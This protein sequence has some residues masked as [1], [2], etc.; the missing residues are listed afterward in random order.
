MRT[1]LA[2]MLALAAMTVPALAQSNPSAVST[3]ASRASIEAVGAGLAVVGK[4]I[5]L[6]PM[7]VAAIGKG[8]EAGARPAALP[9]GTR[10]VTAGPAPDQAVRQ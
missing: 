5:A 2:T 1:T 4:L 8:I 9:L 10:A 7:T 6:P 3:E